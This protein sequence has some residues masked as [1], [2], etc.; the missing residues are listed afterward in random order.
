MSE[1]VWEPIKYCFCEHVGRDVAFEAELVYPDDILP[2]QA[3]RVLAHRCSLGL[4]C[5]QD[6]RPSCK[7][8]GTNPAVDPFE[9]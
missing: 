7:W 5:N 9:T 1:K 3:P 8:A 4:S 2:D 6:G